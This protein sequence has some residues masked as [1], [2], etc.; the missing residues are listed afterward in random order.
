MK[1]VYKIKNNPFK[2]VRMFEEEVMNYTGAPHAI[3]VDS[4]TDALFLCCL[5]K[6]VEAVTIPSQTYL[7]MPMSIIQA[8]GK[9]VFDEY[10]NDWKG[11]YELSPYNIFDCAKRF[12][13]GM[14]D[15]AG[16]LMCL[17]FHSKKILPIG[18]GGMIL[19][20]NWE[21]MQWFKRMRYEGRGERMYQRDDITMMGYNMYMTP[22]QATRGL[23]LLSNL[24][25]HNDDQEEQN[26]YKD[27]TEYTVF[28]DC[29]IIHKQE[30]I[31][32]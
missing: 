32:V 16:S 1:E 24:P 8:G 4:C 25:L 2:I 11:R 21:A 12:T 30:G 28:S 27:L 14:Y 31:L 29:N 5:Y 9:V 23:E 22:S 26:G 15:V 7:S 10:R 13:S 17:S 18:K 20:D 19:T 6:K 3:A